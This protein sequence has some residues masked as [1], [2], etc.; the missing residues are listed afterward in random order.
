MSV[1]LTVVESEDALLTQL[2]C[3]QDGSALNLTIVVDYPFAEDFSKDPFA[4][5]V[6]SV[7]SALKKQGIASFIPSCS[8]TLSISDIKMSSVFWNKQHN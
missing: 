1:L 5:N 7:L 6:M 2:S 4:L 3:F 8:L